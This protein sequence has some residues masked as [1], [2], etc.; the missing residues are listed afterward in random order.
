MISVITI[1]RK[2]DWRGGGCDEGGMSVMKEKLKLLSK[3]EKRNFY[4]HTC[5]RGV[6][7]NVSMTLCFT[8]ILFAQ[9][10]FIASHFIFL[11]NFLSFC[12]FSFNSIA[13]SLCDFIKRMPISS[14][15]S[16]ASLA[17]SCCAVS[18]KMKEGT[19]AAE[20]FRALHVRCFMLFRSKAIYSPK[21]K[22]CL[23]S[24]LF[25]LFPLHYT[26]QHAAAAAA[27][28]RNSLLTRE[29]PT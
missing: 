27:F 22:F 10:I 12:A 15:F 16:C 13:R 25:F 5:A 18:E 26:L 24:L 8:L 28:L 3:S 9:G 11:L 14:F 29:K 4:T 23:H 20:N 19:K 2:C 6:R 7:E 1:A 17:L 21:N